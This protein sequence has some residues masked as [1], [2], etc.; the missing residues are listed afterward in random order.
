MFPFIV[1]NKYAKYRLTCIFSIKVI[2]ILT[3]MLAHDDTGN[4]YKEAEF[5]VCFLFRSMSGMS[6]S[7]K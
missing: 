4:H 6:T 1:N 2:A 3:E 5:W 7:D